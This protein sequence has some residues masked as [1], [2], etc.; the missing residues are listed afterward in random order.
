MTDELSV[1]GFCCLDEGKKKRGKIRNGRMRK[2]LREKAM[3]TSNFQLQ[4]DGQGRSGRDGRKI[5]IDG[6]IKLSCIEN[7]LNIKMK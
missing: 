6:D 2:M 1:S 7:E 3:S 5:I 4:H